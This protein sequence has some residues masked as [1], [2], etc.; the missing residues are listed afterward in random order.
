M[1]RLAVVFDSH[2]RDSEGMFDSCG[3]FVL[4]EMASLDKLVEYFENLYVGIIGMVLFLVRPPRSV[5][6]F[7]IETKLFLALGR[8]NV[9]RDF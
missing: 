8:L 5:N 6:L 2:S 4:V 1:A 9:N 7:P 3:T